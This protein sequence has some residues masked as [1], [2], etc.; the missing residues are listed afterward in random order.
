MEDFL[1]SI[2]CALLAHRSRNT[3]SK[4]IDMFT[5]EMDKAVRE[6]SNKNCFLEFAKGEWTTIS[7]CSANNRLVLGSFQSVNQEPRRVAFH[8][9]NAVC[10]V[11]EQD[12]ASVRQQFG[13]FLSQEIV[14]KFIQENS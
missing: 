10:T 5:F 14:G 6:K 2:D 11:L 3:I 8:K 9:N 12:T 4:E 7:I 13:H 1:N